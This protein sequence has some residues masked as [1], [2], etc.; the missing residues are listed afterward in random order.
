MVLMRK[1]LLSSSLTD[2]LVS[3][4]KHGRS[5]DHPDSVRCARRV[6]SRREEGSV[7][8]SRLRWTGQPLDAPVAARRLRPQGMPAVTRMTIAMVP[9]TFGGQAIAANI[10]SRMAP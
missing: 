8:R 4:K 9:V 1:Q 5:N 10:A 2:W 3:R 7:V 6:Q